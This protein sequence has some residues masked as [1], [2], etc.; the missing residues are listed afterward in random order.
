MAGFFLEGGGDLNRVRTSNDES[1]PGRRNVRGTTAG[2]NQKWQKHNEIWSTSLKY[3]ERENR[4]NSIC[5]IIMYSVI[6][7]SRFNKFLVTRY[8]YVVAISRS[9]CIAAVYPA[10]KFPRNVFLFSPL[11]FA[12]GHCTHCI[13][14][15]II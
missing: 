14:T 6:G 2:F 11:F 9:L 3:T 4:S 10:E 15:H 1:T 13:R 12:I 8:R 5:C 7:K